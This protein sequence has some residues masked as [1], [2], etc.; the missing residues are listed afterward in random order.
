MDL[1][2]LREQINEVDDKL[3]DLY[4]RRM[5][6]VR[7]VAQYKIENDMPVFHPEREEQIIRRMTEKAESDSAAGAK[8]L[9]T[10]LMDVSKVYQHKL[11]AERGKQN[12]FEKLIGES[13]A[14]A[15][16][17]PMA[18]SVACSGVPGAYAH[19]AAQ[20]LFALPEMHYYRQ[21]EDVFEAVSDGEQDFGV[22]PIENSI[23]GSVGAVY[24]LLRRYRLYICKSCKLPIH[25]CLLTSGDV[26]IKN[27]TDVYSHEQALSQCSAFFRS[28]PGMR[29]HVY[30]NTAAAAKYVSQLE[31]QT[32]AAIASPVCSKLYG[33]RVARENLQ[34]TRLNFTRF[35]VVSR[36]LL[37]PRD[38]DKISL[39]LTLPHVQ[40]ALS[41]ILNR[42]SMNALNLTKLESRPL[43]E[44]DF[45]FQF[46][47][48][49]TGSV[50]DQN[51]RSLLS[52]LS[53]EI[54]QFEF[55]GNYA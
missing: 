40:G 42:F 24:D 27:I 32:A 36:D 34:N 7:G 14:Q 15:R 12:G 21:F 47:F 55:L 29:P 52:S 3:L 23:A 51:V 4:C 19:E 25:H 50:R 9:F 53:E 31:S 5:A 41:R 44:T 16:P 35:I 28:H 33:L 49:L 2:E 6:L 8:V 10:A 37:I 17:V 13:L 54:E 38:A 43:P 20:M 18:A 11:L 48:D 1:G 46:Y 26:P 39:S 30:S 45:E 22:L